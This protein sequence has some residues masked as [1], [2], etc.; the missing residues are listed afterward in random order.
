MASRSSLSD[1]ILLDEYVK[2]R[3]AKAF[4]VSTFLPELRYIFFTLNLLLFLILSLLWKPSLVS[5]RDLTYVDFPSHENVTSVANDSASIFKQR[6]F[7]RHKRGKEVGGHHTAY[8]GAWVWFWLFHWL[9]GPHIVPWCK[10]VC[11]LHLLQKN[12]IQPNSSSLILLSITFEH[13][14]NWTHSADWLSS[15][16]LDLSLPTYLNYVASASL[17]DACPDLLHQ[18]PCDYL[19]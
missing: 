8:R 5:V 7:I 15:S 4:I 14:F 2:S 9:S 12:L 1:L 16:N 17:G 19:N 13:P 18:G 10:Q 6:Y 11:L 3:R